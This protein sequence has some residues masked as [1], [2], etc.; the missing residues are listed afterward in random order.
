VAV[1]N[2]AIEV[3]GQQAA[4]AL[5]QITTASRQLESAVGSTTTKINNQNS[6]TGSASNQLKNYSKSTQ[7]ATAATNGL[8]GAVTSLL[9]AFTAIS[10][11]KF[12]F[13]KTA[14]LETQ[15]RSLEVL[16]GSVTKAK[17][18][19]QE[20]QQLGAVTPFTST[21]LIDSAKRLN[22]FG[23]EGD[24]VVETTRRLADVAGATGAELQGLVTA[25]GQV[26]AKGRLQ[27]E[28]LLQFQERGVALQEELRKMYGLSGEEFQKALS[29]GRISAEAVEVAV[30]RLTDAGG[31]YANGAIAQSDTLQGKFS[32]LTDGVEQLARTIGV[33]LT[34]ALKAIFAQAIQVIDAINAALAAGRGGGLAR[35]LAGATGAINLGATSEGVD[36]IA[37]GISQISSQKNKAGIQQNL[38]YLTNYQAVLQRIGTQDPNADRAEQLQGVIQQKIQQ[39]LAAQQ[40]LNKAQAGV[41]RS[42]AVPALLAETGGRKKGKSA[43]ERAAEKAA[44]EAK[45]LAEQTSAQLDAAYKLNALAAA[46]LDIQMSMTK[47]ETLQGQFDKTALERRIKFLDLQKSAKSESERQSLASAQLSE[48]LIANNKYA[49]DK[50]DLL[51]QQTSELYSQ[52]DISGV[53]DKNLQ[54]R[55][56]G[57]FTGATA[58]GTFRTDMDLMPGLTGGKAGKKIEELKTQIAELTNI[59]NIAITSAEGIGNAFA[60]SFQ[61]LIDGS[62]S[63]REALSSFFK[64]VA[65]MFLEMATQIIAKQMTM[66]ILQSILKALGAVAGAGNVGSSATNFG[67]AP[68]VNFNPA[69]FSMPALAANGAY[70]SNGIAAFAR[71]GIVGSPTLFQFA[72]GGTTQTGL[73]GEAGPE[74]IMPLSRGAGGKLGV[75]ASGLREAMGGAPGMGGSPVLNMSFETTRFGDTDYVSRDQL[76]AAMAQTRKQASADGAKRGMSMTLD[77]LQQS[78]QTRSRVGLR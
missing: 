2:I 19:I 8:K 16:T 34:P 47:E 73:M 11:A 61:G 59:G 35:N 77:R 54:N 56:S 18:I 64:D 22:A 13:A 28:E 5:K 70:F 26:Q 46:D 41:F 14:E 9:G 67:G 75:N 71:G 1:A 62:M 50:K 49:K 52:L 43:A 60:N 6:A 29:K 10:A 74:A 25:Y 39:N 30:K 17:T 48:I 40:Q 65:S 36:R 31:K 3:N 38:Q 23:V 58:T 20:L 69:A 32:T 12:V 37:K 33:V 72:N 66:I 68:G 15:T 44:R 51:E 24:K 76:E 27:G 4:N 7:V 55:L 78:P 45:K 57:A 63:A 53:L 42:T 21:E